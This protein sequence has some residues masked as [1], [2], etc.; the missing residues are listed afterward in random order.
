[1]IM[2]HAAEPWINFDCLCFF[3][4]QLNLR[5][6]FFFNVDSIDMRLLWPGIKPTYSSLPA[7]HSHQVTTARKY[8]HSLGKIA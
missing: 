7:H 6:H 1:M 3:Y 2:R 8:A 5:I 4:M